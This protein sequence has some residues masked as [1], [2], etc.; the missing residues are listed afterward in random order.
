MILGVDTEPEILLSTAT[1]RYGPLK[2]RFRAASPGTR[3]SLSYPHT[4]FRAGDEASAD[5]EILCEL[6]DASPMAG[7]RVFDANGVW[8][9]R[10]DEN[11]MEQVY[12]PIRGRNG[13]WEPLMSLT[14]DPSIRSARYVR[15]RLS[16][17][18]GV[19]ALAYPVDEYLSSRLLARRGGMILHASSVKV[20]EQALLFIGHSGAGKST[21]AE[22]A[23]SAGAEVL[24]D[25]RTIV[26]LD[27][28]TPKAWGTPWHG[29][30]A[31][32]SAG[33]API[34]AMFLLIQD[35]Q[36]ALLPM[37]PARAF[38]EVFVRMYQPT[39]DHAEVE[40]VIDS[41]QEV[42]GVVPMYELRCRKSTAGFDLARS[43]AATYH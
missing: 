34:A 32:S 10:R 26:T 4:L 1:L 12:Y 11:G 17:D 36:D 19:I 13:D 41:L 33:S 2:L 37:K 5:T 9:L 22:F 21:M 42:V 30:C 16:G 31:R 3:L 18:G 40:R 29:T 23:G 7:L 15:R 43:V 20:G 27:H 25:D 39:A 14:F 6:G 28:G 8:E 35:V 24:T 38:S